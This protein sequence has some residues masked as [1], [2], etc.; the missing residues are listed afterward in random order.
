MDEAGLTLY[1]DGL[2][3]GAIRKQGW[4]AA[5]RQDGRYLVWVRVEEDGIRV[6]DVTW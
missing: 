4:D 2:Y 5:L 1:E 6:T 3:I